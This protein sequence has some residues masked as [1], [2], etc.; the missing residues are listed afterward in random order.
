M[1]EA[2][3]AERGGEVDFLTA[4]AR[5]TPDKIAAIDDRP[6][7]TLAELSFAEVEARANRLAHALVALGAKPH[8][9]VAWCGPNSIDC[10]ILIHAARKV[11][12]TPVAVN[13][14]LTDDEAA[15]VIRDS[16]AVAA[17]IDAE[18]APRFARIVEGAKDLRAVLVFGGEAGEG[19]RT[20]DAFL[21]GH[22]E[23]PPQIGALGEKAAT[24]HYT[25]GTTGTPKGAVRSTT[26]R[27]KQAKELPN[28]LD[29]IGYR[30]GDVYITTGPLY[31]SGPSEMAM[32]SAMYGNTIVLQ[33]HFDPEDWLRLVDRHRVTLVYSAPTPI[34]RIVSLPSEIKA[35]YDRSSVRIALAA[36]APWSYALKLAFLD[37]FPEESLW[38]I[39]GS[40]ELG[41]NTLLAPEDQRRK[42]GSCGKPIPGIEIALFDDDG[43]QV[44]EPDTP[45]ELYVRSP[46]LF[47]AYHNAPEKTV[48]S[49]R[50]GFYT[51][52]DI[53][54]FDDDGYFYICDRKT[55]MI[56]SGGVN[57]YALE[58][59]NAIE[60]HPDVLEAAVIGVPSEEWGESLLALV[61]P[62]E[63]ASPDVGALEEHV[64]ARLAGFKVPRQ[65]ELRA[66]LP[67]NGAG[68][69]Q[70]RDLREPYWRGRERRIL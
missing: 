48:A 10:L 15:F 65:W 46:L 1:D 70:K 58:V 5:A 55:D 61:V 2:S 53:A 18:W 3:E 56:I 13:D 35:R 57:I 37:D 64:R 7:G 67:H 50:A 62:A 45:G 38:E 6:D 43:K 16:G 22:P 40:T 36:A 17:W 39:Y 4:H 12:L 9:R 21:E 41:A 19:Q 11:C 23:T 27:A 44:T 52:G 34:R 32:L 25:S 69:V 30:A 20:A 26:G 24:M 63:G 68:K 47:D 51:V 42:P 66:E 28:M 31:H 60:L 8:D 49:E 14:R 33:R 29:L 59:E 54:T